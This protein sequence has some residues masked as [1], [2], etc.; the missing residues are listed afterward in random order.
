[1]LWT[2][3][4]PVA[5]WFALEDTHAGH[6]TAGAL[7]VLD[8]AL[9][10]SECKMCVQLL[11]CCVTSC[12]RTGVELCCIPLQC[13]DWQMCMACTGF[14]WAEKKDRATPQLMLQRIAMHVCACG[15]SQL[16]TAPGAWTMLCIIHTVTDS[17]MPKPTVAIGKL[18]SSSSTVQ[19]SP[20]LVPR[21]V[22][23]K[24]L[25]STA[26]SISNR[27]RRSTLICSTKLPM[28]PLV[29]VYIWPWLDM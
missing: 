18:Q 7:I 11:Y 1:M 6:A 27:V 4:W 22:E 25:A 21:Q 26:C 3:P 12:M 9:R 23:L 20:W 2:P 13:T 19:D 15:V 28:C 5:C 14:V 16:L 17:T 24:V 29:Q 8:V 10:L